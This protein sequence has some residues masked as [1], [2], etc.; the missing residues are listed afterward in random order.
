MPCGDSRGQ[1]EDSFLG[2]NS[3][4]EK[5]WIACFLQPSQLPFLYKII[6]FSLLC[7]DLNVACCFEDP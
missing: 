3:A 7:G 6:L 4:D 1:Q 2:N 5:P